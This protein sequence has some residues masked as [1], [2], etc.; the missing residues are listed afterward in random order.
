MTIYWHPFLADMLRLSYANHLLI[1]EQLPLGDLPLEADLLLI[2]RDPKV[3]LPFPLE[4]LGQRTLVEYKSPEDTADQ[5]ALEQLEIYAMLYV[6]REGLRRRGDLTLW[7]MASR[8]AVNVSQPGRAELVGLQQV[9]PGVSRG[10]LDGFPTMLVDLQGVPF[11]PDTVPLHMVGRGAQERALTE[12]LIDHR[13]DYPK[14][15]ELLQ[16]LHARSLLEVLSMRN[17]TPEQMGLDYDALIRL[18]GRDRA[19][20][21]IGPKQATEHFGLKALLDEAAKEH[22][23]QEVREWLEGRSKPSG[24][25]QSAPSQN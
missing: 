16:R 1:Q 21:L 11:S 5:A 24:P 14:Q 15:F 8:F 6:R 2:R 18:I 3:V 7:L 25:D 23:D 17:V 4:F 22:G 19:L 13:Q 10:T 12:Y 20:D 9:G